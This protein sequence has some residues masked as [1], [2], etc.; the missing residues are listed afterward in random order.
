M[1]TTMIII[2]TVLIIITAIAII[3]VK[4]MIKILILNT[5]FP[6]ILSDK[7]LSI[8]INAFFSVSKL[9]T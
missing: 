7:Y 8:F 1:I 4:R 9:L 6:L 3:I 2:D 5:V